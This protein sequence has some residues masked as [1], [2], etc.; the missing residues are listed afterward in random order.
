MLEGEGERGVC[1]WVKK[2]SS[3]GARATDKL[4]VVSAE[5]PPTFA[6]IVPNPSPFVTAKLALLPIPA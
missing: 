4:T 2:S 1:G 5:K 3:G 6:A